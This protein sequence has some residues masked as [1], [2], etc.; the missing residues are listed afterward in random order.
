MDTFG[1]TL[2]TIGAAWLCLLFAFLLFDYVQNVFNREWNLTFRWLEFSG[3]RDL[4]FAGDSVGRFRDQDCPNPLIS[5]RVGFG[6]RPLC[7]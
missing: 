5:A 7:I 1:K 3:H 4:G 2:A 6:R